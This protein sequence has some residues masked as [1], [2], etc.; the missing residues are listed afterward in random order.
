[1]LL[2]RLIIKNAFRHRLRSLLTIIGVAVALLAFGLMRTVLDAWNAGVS[3]SSANR[4]VTR[5]AISITQPLPY[6]YKGRIR[7]VTGVDIVA[8]G[9]W[10]GGVYQDE[11]NFFANFAMEAEEFFKLYPE[12]VVAPKE[13]RAFLADRKAAIIGRKLATR[14]NWHID[15][16]ITLR[17][18]IF[19]GEWPMTIRA[20]YKG[21]RPDTDETALYFHWSYLD[22]T[23]KKRAPSR[24]GQISFFMIG[25]DDASRA[26]EI[27]K[28]IDALFVN[29]QAETLTETEKAFQMGFVSMSAAILMAITVV[30]YVVICIILAVAA[31]TMAMSARERLGEFAV[32]KTLGFGAAALGG[33]LLA[34]SLILSL[35]GTLLAV[36][37]MPPIAKGFST[38]L[39]QFFP[40]FFVSRQTIL[41]A[42]GFGV[43][44]GVCAAIVPAVR[45]GTVRIAAAFRRIG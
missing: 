20:I 41:L 34:E 8:A 37:L 26:A 18:T 1:M 43:L 24:A 15:D 32:M 38:Y 35:S 39:S 33:M 3:A 44:V 2:L 10:F 16:T 11:K 9:N 42:F 25:I 27:S 4:L 14:F 19:P 7:Q 29:S 5:N 17:G 12:L 22:E 30:S 36:A 45:V 28:N 6:A 40:I 21:A 13:R 23:M 31:N